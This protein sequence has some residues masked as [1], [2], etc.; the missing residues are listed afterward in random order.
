MTLTREAELEGELLVRY[1]LEDEEIMKT[2]TSKVKHV[3]QKYDCRTC[4]ATPGQPCRTASG[5]VASTEHSDRYRQACD[6][7]ELPIDITSY[8][9][10]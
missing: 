6:A 3:M 4:K 2:L 7:G 1:L 10:S 8:Y 5:T 9:A